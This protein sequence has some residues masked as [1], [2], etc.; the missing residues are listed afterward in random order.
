M[1]HPQGAASE[2]FGGFQHSINRAAMEQQQLTQVKRK[3][4]QGV[5]EESV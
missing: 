1:Y 4:A 3:R 5:R 2:D